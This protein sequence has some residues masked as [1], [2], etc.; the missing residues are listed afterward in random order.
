MDFVVNLERRMLRMMAAVEVAAAA[1]APV[2]VAMMAVVK[3]L[4]WVSFVVI[5][6]IRL[7]AAVV[8]ASVAIVAS[9]AADAVIAE[10]A[11]AVAVADSHRCIPDVAAAA[12][13]ALFVLDADVGIG[14]RVGDEIYGAADRG[15]VVVRKRK[16][17]RNEMMTMRGSRTAVGRNPGQHRHHRHRRWTMATP[18]V[19]VVVGR[20]AVAVAVGLGIAALGT[21]AAVVYQLVFCVRRRLEPGLFWCSLPDDTERC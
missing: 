3:C 1:A 20:T 21:A 18:V 2:G 8:V 4:E 19:V 15:G 5:M 7:V 6:V 9:I 13:P 10:A 11:V 16:V 17:G 12:A 14:V